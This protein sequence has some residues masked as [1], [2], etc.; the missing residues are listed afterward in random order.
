MSAGG[1]ISTMLASIK[2]NSR[3]K[4]SHI[5]FEKDKKITL[6]ANQLFLKN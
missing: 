4:K 6:K 5:P 1:H 3:R 2:N